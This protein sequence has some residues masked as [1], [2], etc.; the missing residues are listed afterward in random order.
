MV[1]FTR[2]FLLS[3]LIHESAYFPTALPTELSNF[4]LFVH[5]KGDKLCLST[6]FTCIFLV[7]DNIN[8]YFFYFPCQIRNCYWFMFPSISK[9]STYTPLIQF[10]PYESRNLLFQYFPI[11]PVS[12]IFPPLFPFFLSSNIHLFLIF[13]LVISY[14]QYGIKGRTW[15]VTLLHMLNLI[16]TPR[17]NHHS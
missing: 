13:W 2:F 4:R 17:M 14:K 8:C 16:S 15:K 11:S 1:H 5:L 7:M 3:W 9:L 10:P 12:L 6:V